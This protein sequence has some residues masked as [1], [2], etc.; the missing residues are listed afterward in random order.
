MPPAA[1]TPIMRYNGQTARDAFMR[2]LQTHRKSAFYPSLLAFRQ[3]VGDGLDRSGR[4]SATA[5]FP[6]GVGHPAL[7]RKT[8]LSHCFY[9]R[10][11]AIIYGNT[12]KEV[13][14]RAA[15]KPQNLPQG[16][17]A[18]QRPAPPCAAPAI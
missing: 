18:K 1:A 11:C 12:K 5:K 17:R 10:V 16:P 13:T 3:F 2:P 15:G 4:F 7:H 9:P 6:G 14:R 8:R